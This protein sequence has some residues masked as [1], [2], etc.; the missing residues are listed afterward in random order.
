MLI[1]KLE[2]E[3]KIVTESLLSSQFKDT[4]IFLINFNQMKIISEKNHAKIFEQVGDI[5]QIWDPVKNYIEQYK[6]AVQLDK[7]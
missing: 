6:I 4:K 3:N 5:V 2:I 1:I 7:L